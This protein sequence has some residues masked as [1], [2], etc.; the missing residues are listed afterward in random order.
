MYELTFYATDD[1]DWAQ[2][3]E[4]IDDDTG[5]ALDTTGATFKLEVLDCGSAALTASTDDAT[6]DVVDG[7]LQ[8]RFTPTQLGSL[9]RGNT[10]RLG[11]TMTTA[12]GTTQLFIGS[13]ALI[14]GGLA[15]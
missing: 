5:E 12:D 4:L 11:C 1:A 14:D 15:S 6:M 7:G 9:T 2:R 3:V 8:W 13:L 10:Y